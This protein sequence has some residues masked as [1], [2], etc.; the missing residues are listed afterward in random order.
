MPQ[1]SAPAVIQ[2]EVSM[3]RFRISLSIIVAALGLTLA[4]APAEALNIVSF[5]A[6]LGGSDSNSCALATEPCHSI[7][8]ALSKTD[9]GGEIRCIDGGVIS[10]HILIEKPVTIDCEPSAWAYGIAGGNAVTVILNE[11]TYPNGVV[12]LRNLTL[13][14]LLGNGGDGIGVTGG[15]AAVHIENCQIQGFAQQGIDFTPSSSMDLFV[16]DTVISSNPGDGIRVRPTGSAGAKVVLD[17]VNAQDNV[18]GVRVD[19]SATSVSNLV[20]IR[21][22]TIAGGSGAGLS[23]VE[24]G[25]GATVVMLEG[26]SAANNTTQGVVVSGTNA[27]VRMRDSTTSGNGI[28]LQA[29]SGGNI[30]SQGGN[31]VAGNITNGAFTSSQPLQ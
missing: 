6:A 16:T 24:S 18:S 28:G 29:V 2:G 4:A 5:V 10:G 8:G 7:N 9:P 20:T 25:T 26:S 21:D 11:A 3:T 17:N 30:I 22:S 12:T 19:G 23:V 27:A 15:G 31:T 14:G 1:Y 13:N